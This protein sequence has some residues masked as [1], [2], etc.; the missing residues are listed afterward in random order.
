MIEA[1][2]RHR[3]FAALMAQRAGR[4]ENAPWE[5]DLL[6]IGREEENLAEELDK[7]IQKL[8]G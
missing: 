8:G 3:E 6:A 7:S 2:D 4:P 5:K 1:R